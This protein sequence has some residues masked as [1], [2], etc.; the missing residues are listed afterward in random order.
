MFPYID[1]PNGCIL[2]TFNGNC[3]QQ[4]PLT[5]GSA[6]GLLS[7]LLGAVGAGLSV[8]SGGGLGLVA[9]ATMIGNSLNHEMLHV[10]HSGNISANSGIMGNKKPYIIIGRTHGYD[11]NGYKS[12]YGYPAND[13]VYL[14]N[15]S[16]FTR[17]KHIHLQTSATD[18]E[19]DEIIK[20]L[21][22]GVIL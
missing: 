17:V 4:L 13:T 7:G 5:S 12:F 1:M 21:T 2:Y 6:S 11:A 10:S 3:S 15:V 9:G 14:N 22:E 16:G 8:A 18:P 20:Y 19:Y